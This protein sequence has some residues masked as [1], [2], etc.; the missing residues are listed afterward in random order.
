MEDESDL[1]SSSNF[2][3]NE[4]RDDPVEIAKKQL[5][6]GKKFLKKIEDEEE[7]QKA[8]AAAPQNYL[9]HHGSSAPQVSTFVV[10][11]IRNGFLVVGSGSYQFD[12]DPEGRALYCKDEAAVREAVKGILDAFLT[13]STPGEGPELPPGVGSDVPDGT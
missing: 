5:E 10:R 9:S 13:Q 4:K 1:E 6:L 2:L 3:E 8:R 12:P 7:R 11:R